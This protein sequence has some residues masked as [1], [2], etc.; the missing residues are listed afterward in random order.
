MTQ[1]VCSC[2]ET[3]HGKMVLIIIIVAVVIL[4]GVIYST[5][6]RVFE[7]ICKSIGVGIIAGII[8][9]IAHIFYSDI[10]WGAVWIIVIGSCFA[11]FIGFGMKYMAMSDDEFKNYQ[12][13]Q[14]REAQQDRKAWADASRRVHERERN[15]RIC[16]H[17]QFY[18]EINN[19]Y[20]P[21][22]GVCRVRCRPYSH[23]EPED[24]QPDYSCKDFK[25]RS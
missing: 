6:P 13:E 14:E 10:T 7:A 19:N 18:T 8:A 17:C 4:L 22:R 2:H 24:V 16:R 1:G 23:D 20:S 25:W 3:K 11:G 12:F 21:Y 15:R 9:C 5:M